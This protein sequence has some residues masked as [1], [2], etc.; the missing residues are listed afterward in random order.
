METKLTHV[1]RAGDNGKFLLR[2]GERG[3]SGH[4]TSFAIKSEV[5]KF[6]ALRDS[7]AARLDAAI[8]SNTAMLLDRLATRYDPPRTDADLL[9]RPG[10]CDRGKRE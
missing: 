2:Q 7:F 1:L 5:P 3:W 4:R 6:S 9:R 10:A 8:R